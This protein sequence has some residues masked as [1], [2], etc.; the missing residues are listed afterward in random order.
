MR[1]SYTLSM[2]L[3]RQFLI[4]FASVLAGLVA[5]ILLFGLAELTQ[6]ATNRES[7]GFLI[8]LQMA[9]L[10]L[11]FLI[12]K[13]LPIAVLFGA[14]FTFIRLTRTNQLV[15]SRGVG[16]SAWQFLAPSLF[17]AMV[18]GAF[19]V[20]VF[21]PFSSA[22]TS[23][24]EQLEARY[25]RGQSSLLAVSPSGLWLRQSNVDGQSV[26][27][28]NRV[29]QQGEELTD[30]TIYLYQGIDHFSGRMD[31][32][33]AILRDEFWELNDVLITGPDQP[34]RREDI[35]RLETSLTVSQIQNSFAPPET[36]SFWEL[37]AF[38]STLRQAGFSALNHR[39]HWH[40]LLSSPMLLFAMVLIAATFS[41]GAARRGFSGVLIAAGVFA[42]FLL[43]V[44]SDVVLAMGL[45]GAVPVVLAAWAPAGISTLLGIA[46]IFQ[47]EDG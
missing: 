10:Q 25:L 12:Q 46:A 14:I 2:Y 30:V 24:F 45:S 16:V 28:A 35:F 36:L 6:R 5:I 32:S 39:I 40:T 13:I 31:A 29:S 8:V 7:V 19:G 43:Y 22:A 1:L 9:F 23:R 42:G 27:H 4:G 37:P 41:L 44:V 33:T 34:P 18:I 21:D 26:I 15:I 20:T 38:I 11:P 3:G 47:F 17:L